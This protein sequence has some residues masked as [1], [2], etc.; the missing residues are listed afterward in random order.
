MSRDSRCQPTLDRGVAE[1]V[2]RKPLALFRETRAEVDRHKQR[3]HD[4]AKI[5][6]WEAE[7]SP[8]VEAYEALCH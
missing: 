1:P 5:L 8:M 3:S 4:S 6:C 2:L 7:C